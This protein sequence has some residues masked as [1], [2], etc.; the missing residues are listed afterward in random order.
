[1]YRDGHGARYITLDTEASRARLAHP[2][3]L[4]LPALRRVGMRMAVTMRMAVG[5][6][7]IRR[8]LD[9]H[10]HD[11]AVAHAALG[12]DVIGECLDLA[13]HAFQHGHLKAAFL[14]DMHV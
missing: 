12:D 10:H 4:L 3:V 7:V 14:V 11:L 2:T 5:M 8:R 1:M 13:A 9:R 6:P